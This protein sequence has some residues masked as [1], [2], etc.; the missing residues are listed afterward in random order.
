VNT[1]VARYAIGVAALAVIVGSLALA[2]IALRRRY[3]PTWTG[4]VAR[5]AEF[6][7]GLTSLITTSELLGAVGLFRLLPI[8]VACA[9]I[10][11]GTAWAAGGA[12]GAPRRAAW[13]SDLGTT[14][15]PAIAT[16]LTT[17]ISLLAA[18]T[19]TALWA[20][21]TLQS[22]DVGV[23]TFDSLYYH[24]PWAATFAQTGHVTPLQYDIQYMLQFYPAS[25][26]LL[27][28]LG[29]LLLTRDTLSPALNFL[30]FGLTL[31][32]AWCIGR[33]RGIG[34]ATMLGAALA[35]AVPMIVFS[36]A[37][38]ADN[39]VA[40][41]AMLLAA[42]ALFVNAEG[43][44]AAVVLAGIAAGAAIG[45][46]LTLFGPVIAL[47]A[48]VI[49][50][51]PAG[52]RT[53][54]AALWLVPLIL[55]G[56]FWYLR[57]LISVGNPLPWVSFGILPTPAPALA[58]NTG[59]SVF[60]YLTDGRFWSHF[61]VSG[62]ASE[63]GGW[64]WAV[65]GAAILGPVLCLFPGSDRERRMLGLVALVSVFSYMLTPES[66]QGP[67]GDP[68]GFG[69]NMRYLAPGLTLSLAVLPL[70]PAFATARR[71]LVLGLFLVVVLIAT[72]AKPSLWPDAHAAGAVGL[73]VIA[74][75]VVAA[76]SYGRSRIPTGWR[77]TRALVAA[78]AAL[79][80]LAG[81]AAGYAWQRH[82]LR[83]RYVFRPGVSY[84]ARVWAMFRPIRQA[85]VGVAGTYGGFF[86]YPLFG[87]DLS[88]AVQ[89]IAHHGPHGSFTPIASCPAWRAAVNSGHFRY[90]VT[91]PGREFW[92]PKQ[93]LPAPETRWVASDPNARVLYTR[94]ALGQTITVFELRG[95]LDPAACPKS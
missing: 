89:Y 43:R 11:L 42:V 31:L 12:R 59:Y 34:P 45:I 21:P 86:S 47:S 3:Y 85:R 14:G 94:R 37:G 62:M 77:F 91:T 76:L 81:A 19:V 57:N 51:A 64:W 6:V 9:A 49:A 69:F 75:G 4:A 87:D 15:R 68:V 7:I 52:R 93:L 8:V 53:R 1:T 23:H 72:V 61:F 10:G 2:A 32:A 67:V 30:W 24:L 88:N 70:A 5:L 13:R 39:D 90:L 73:G 16:Q 74:L 44:S 26:E 92:R 20:S 66:A 25:A 41:V 36:Q 46:K 54:T 35:L 28:A 95:S 83:G 63:L 65:L 84:L 18:A 56:C 33:P 48:G 71:Q 29:I 40:G 82:Y 38:S 17:V 27:H 80:V 50:I 79:L 60:H 22:Y 58:Q 78:A 55:A